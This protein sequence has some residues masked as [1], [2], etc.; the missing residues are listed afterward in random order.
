MA[1]SVGTTRARI[2][3]VLEEYLTAYNSG[4]GTAYRYVPRR[5]VNARLPAFITIPTNFNIDRINNH[6]EDVTQLYSIIFYIQ[7]TAHGVESEIEKKVELHLDTIRR[8]LN[9]KPEL[10]D[11]ANNPLP[12]VFDCRVIGGEGIVEVRYPNGV[13]DAPWYLAIDLTYRTKYIDVV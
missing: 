12:N 5:L 11:S 9:S 1:H 13:L 8:F 4:I 10:Q 6:E 2:K 3:T 7:P